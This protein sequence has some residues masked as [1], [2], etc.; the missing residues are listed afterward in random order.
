MA[1]LQWN[2]SRSGRWNRSWA[3]SHHQ[4]LFCPRQAPMLLFLPSSGMICCMFLPQL[5]KGTLCSCSRTAAPLFGS[6]SD[7]LPAS[8][9]SQPS[10]D[11][12]GSTLADAWNCS[13]HARR[14]KAASA[15]PYLHL[16]A[17]ET[18]SG[19]SLT[20]CRRDVIQLLQQTL[21]VLAQTDEAQLVWQDAAQHTEAALLAAMAA[22]LPEALPQLQA[23]PWDRLQF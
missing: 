1:L 21:P 3:A 17:G 14:L 16:Q 23:R 10:T 5:F 20:C 12:Q 22:N 4:T 19:W 13:L 18:R 9:V 8:C 2:G 11:A 7:Q 15:P 6:S